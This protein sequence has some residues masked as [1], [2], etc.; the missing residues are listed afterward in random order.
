[1]KRHTTEWK[2]RHASGSGWWGR[3]HEKDTDHQ[4]DDQPLARLDAELL[5]RFLF[6]LEFYEQTGQGRAEGRVKPVQ[7]R[8]RLEDTTIEAAQE[9]L[10]GSPNGVLMVQ[11]ELSGF[12]GRWT[13]TAAIAGRPRSRVLVAVV[14]WRTICAEPYHVA[15]GFSEPFDQPAWRYPARRDPAAV[16]RM[17]RRRLFAADVAHRHASGGC[18]E[19]RADPE[20]IGGLRLLIERLT[21]LRRPISSKSTTMTVFCASTATRRRCEANLRPNISG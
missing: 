10:A 6:E 15:Q 13:N 20:S 5:R 3:P 1:M 9:A 11:D 12:F 14:Q 7:K 18:R 4:R 8:Q 19:G 16:G 2:D 21:R 17:L